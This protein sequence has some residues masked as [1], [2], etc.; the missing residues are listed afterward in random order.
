M[1]DKEIMQKALVC[2]NCG[3]WCRESDMEYGRCKLMDGEWQWGDD[4]HIWDW[5]ERGGWSSG[6]NF[7]CIHWKQKEFPMSGV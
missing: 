4:C 1:T 3:W 2:K 7:G 5:S 6:R